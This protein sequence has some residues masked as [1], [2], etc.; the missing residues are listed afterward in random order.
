MT[1]C[2]LIYWSTAWQ[3]TSVFHTRSIFKLRTCIIVGMRELNQLLYSILWFITAGFILFG[4]YDI[5][6]LYD[7]TSLNNIA[8]DRSIDA[9]NVLDFIFAFYGCARI[10][11]SRGIRPLKQQLDSC[12]DFCAYIWDLLGGGR[13]L[14]WLR[15]T[16][17]P[18]GEDSID[19]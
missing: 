15:A 4:K 1:S 6:F 14:E 2:Q 12:S 5:N 10:I 3:N 8:L 7:N 18:G 16:R 17:N 9:C 19:R 13:Q 11:L